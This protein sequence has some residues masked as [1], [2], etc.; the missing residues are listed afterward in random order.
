M[1]YRKFSSVF[2]KNIRILFFSFFGRRRA[3][4]LHFQI[5]SYVQIQSCTYKRNQK[6][7]HH[8]IKCYGT[9]TKKYNCSKYR[10]HK[11]PTDHSFDP[12]FSHRITDSFISGPGICSVSSFKTNSA[13][14]S[15]SLALAESNSLCAHTGAK[16]SS[17]SA[18][19]T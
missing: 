2:N 4:N 17:T 11:Y 5:L 15:C 19:I 3:E 10:Q 7:E 16:I 18:G 6:P 1:K 12:L 14:C 9:V 8:A 13:D